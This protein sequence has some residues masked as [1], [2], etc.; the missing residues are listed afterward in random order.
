M[1]VIETNGQTGKLRIEARP[2]TLLH[3]YCIT[4]SA[5]QTLIARSPS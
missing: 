3:I 2:Q 4:L 5:C 1:M